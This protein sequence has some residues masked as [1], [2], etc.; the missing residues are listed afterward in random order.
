MQKN[1]DKGNERHHTKESHD[2]LERYSRIG[3]DS[4]N[5]PQGL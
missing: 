4:D 5:S 1:C 3:V 2:W